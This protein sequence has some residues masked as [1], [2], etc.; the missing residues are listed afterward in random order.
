MYPPIWSHFSDLPSSQL[1]TS[2]HRALWDHSPLGKISRLLTLASSFFFHVV[3]MITWLS[4][5]TLTDRCPFHN[6]QASRPRG[7]RWCLPPSHGPITLYLPPPQMPASEVLTSHS[8]TILT[9]FHGGMY[10]FRVILLHLLTFY[11]K[12][13]VTIFGNFNIIFG[14]FNININYSSDTLTSQ[15]INVFSSTLLS[16]THSHLAL[17]LCHYKC[18]HP[19][20]DLTFKHSLLWWSFSLWCSTPKTLRPPPNSQSSEPSTFLIFFIHSVS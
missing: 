2:S 9:L 1:P 15:S 14:D 20:H 5:S 18:L 8:T 10:L 6:S 7:G 12:F 3:L 16:A 17:R 13:T 19:A 4:L 11:L